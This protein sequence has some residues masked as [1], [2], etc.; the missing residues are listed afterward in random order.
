MTSLYLN[1]EAQG[2]PPLQPAQSYPLFTKTQ[3]IGVITLL[4]TAMFVWI[5]WTIRQKNTPKK[6]EPTMDR[7][8]IPED[9]PRQPS[10]SSTQRHDQENTGNTETKMP[11]W[12]EFGF[13]SEAQFQ[14][15]RREELRREQEQQGQPQN[16]NRE[17]LGGGG[18]AV[19]APDPIRREAIAGER[20]LTAAEREDAAVAQAMMQSGAAHVASQY[21]ALRPYI[22]SALIE[23]F[24]DK[25]GL[26]ALIN[27]KR[28]ATRA[29]NEGVLALLF[30]KKEEATELKQRIAK[31]DEY[32][33]QNLE[34][35]AI[36]KSQFD[37]GMT[38]E[39]AKIKAAEVL[40]QSF[41]VISG[42]NK[43]EHVDFTVTLPPKPAA[44]REEEVEEKPTE[45][46]LAKQRKVEKEIA[47]NHWEKGGSN[48]KDS[49]NSLA[50]KNAEEKAAKAK[51]EAQLQQAAEEEAKDAARAQLR[52]RRLQIRTQVQPTLRS[53]A[54]IEAKKAEAQAAADEAR[55]KEEERRKA[56]REA[57]LKALKR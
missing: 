36:A 46:Q 28:G 48:V 16:V 3:I 26:R 6:L 41:G 20:P 2:E 50:V 29:L 19:R 57:R 32:A 34:A 17:Q 43:R 35:Q 44:A 10:T 11:E 40:A 14:R 13:S 5:S 33:A 39:K 52:E 15:H 25:P 24:K 37:D 47:R 21:Q 12:L 9:S 56:L 45:A 49:K 42:E 31:I 8:T 7:R 53:A 51:A 1:P 27:I 54:E 18:D 55:A 22:E 23:A 4:A 30:Q 38:V